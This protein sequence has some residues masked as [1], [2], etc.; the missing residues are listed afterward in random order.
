MRKRHQMLSGQHQQ[1]SNSPL[2]APL[3][4]S[5]ATSR[6][7][8]PS[9]RQ[10]LCWWRERWGFLSFN[11]YFLQQSCGKSTPK[12]LIFFKSETVIPDSS[13]SSR[14]SHQSCKHNSSLRLQQT[15]LANAAE[16]LLYSSVPFK[17]ITI[18][19][20]KFSHGKIKPLKWPCNQYTCCYWNIRKCV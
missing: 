17:Y 6:E 10:S 5:P 3:L 1:K 19:N 14:H 8:A 16:V 2:Q 9:K 20:S 12:F 7:H 11:S 18:N 4:F 15:L 13:H